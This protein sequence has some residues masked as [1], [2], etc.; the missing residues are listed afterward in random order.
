MGKKKPSPKKIPSTRRGH[1]EPEPV[2]IESVEP[3][4]E[5][6]GGEEGGGGDGVGEDKRVVG[7]GKKNI[8]KTYPNPGRTCWNLVPSSSDSSAHE[9]GQLWTESHIGWLSSLHVCHFGIHGSRSLG[10]STNRN[11]AAE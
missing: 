4:V 11:K 8:Q 2:E 7:A 9:A 5:E 10:D 1:V 3:V 6:D